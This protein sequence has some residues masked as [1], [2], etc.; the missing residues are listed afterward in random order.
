MNPLRSIGDVVDRVRTEPPRILVVGDLLLDRWWE[1]GAHRVSREAPVAVVELERELEA[2]GGAANTAANLAALGAAVSVVGIVGDDP[3]GARLLSILDAAGV[4]IAG[5]VVDSATRTSTKTRV[6]GE[7]Q[8]LLRV[9]RGG[10]A[11]SAAARDRVAAAVSGRDIPVVVVCDYGAG[12][13]DDNVARALGKRAEGTLI[14]DAHNPQRWHA[15][16]PDVV[17]PSAAEVERLVGRDLG[18][19]PGRVDALIDDA[20]GVIA[21]SGAG[22]VIATFDVDGTAVIAAGHR[23]HRTLARRVPESQASGAG[24]SFT[25]GVALALACGADVA[26]AADLGQRAADVVVS[27]PRT[28]VCTLEDLAAADGALVLELEDAALAIER[29][30]S[31]G[32]RVVLTNGCFDVLHSGHA[33]HLRSA[34]RLGDIL[35]VAVNDDDSV[36]RLKGRGRPI[37]SLDDRVAVLAALGCVDVILPLRDD[38]ARAVVRRIRPDVYAKGGDYTPNMLVET[39]AVHDVGGRVHILDYLPERSTSALVD[40]IRTGRAAGVAG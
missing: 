2:P 15:A 28:A 20:D 3:D 33:A 38:D 40:R 4:D 31:T 1:G 34:K 16:R 5:V 39:E 7:D 10:G 12:S 26:L 18:T 29:S 11:P 37:N 22:A 6:V 9:D 23:V 13:L 27:A 24:D 30:R 32:R 19:G 14:V 8:I 35:V 25:A 17:T 21:A 36:A